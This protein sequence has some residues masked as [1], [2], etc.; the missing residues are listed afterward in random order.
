VSALSS[1][2][3]FKDSTIRDLH[4]SKKFLSQELD[5]EKWN[6]KVL[7][8]DCEVLKAWYDKAIRVGRLLMKKL[9]VMVLDGIVANV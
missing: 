6:I 5:T 9:G 1:S 7:E 3:S 8:G 4:A 2:L